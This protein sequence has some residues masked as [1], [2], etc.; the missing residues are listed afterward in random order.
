VK[1]LRDELLARS[2]LSRDERRGV[3]LGDHLDARLHLHHLR[4]VTDEAIDGRAE[5]ERAPRL[6]QLAAHRARALEPGDLVQELVQVERLPE[7]VRRALLE[8]RDRLADV[9]VSRH[10]DEVGERRILANRSQQREPV[11]SRQ[12][13]VAETVSNACAA[14]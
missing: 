12:L 3:A 2:A 13:N 10:E 11:D 1:Q 6:G 9:G 4:R 8:G 7:V 14:R 5:S